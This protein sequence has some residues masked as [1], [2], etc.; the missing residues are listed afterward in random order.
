[1]NHE[2]VSCLI[3]VVINGSLREASGDCADGR[4]VTRDPQRV[5]ATK[6]SRVS[7]TGGP[8]VSRG[9]NDRVAASASMISADRRESIRDDTKDETV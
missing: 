7:G 5:C 1:L 6:S 9:V 4:R 3:Y 2:L 8:P